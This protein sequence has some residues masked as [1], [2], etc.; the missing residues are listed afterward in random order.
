MTVTPYSLTVV[1]PVFNEAAEIGG[2]LAAL[3]SALSATSFAADVVVVDDGSSDGSAA[4]VQAARLETP[5]QLLAQENQGRF[6]ARRAGIEHAEGDFCLLLDS[7]VRIDPGALAYLEQRLQAGPEEQVW[8]AHVDIE[9][10]GNPYGVFW[11]VLTR[12]AYWTYFREPRTTSFGLDDFDRFPK[13]TTCFLAPRDLLLAAT[14]AFRSSYDDPRFANDDAPLIRWLAGRVPINI[15]P[16]FS[17]RY[18]S[19]R[20]LGPFLRHAFHRGT[21]F[22]DG[23]GHRNAGWFPI[24]VGLFAG[25]AGC[26]A[27]ALRRPLATISA[28]TAATSAAGAAVA[29]S[30][31]RAADAP[32]MAWVT[33]LYAS[34]HIAGMWRGLFMRVRTR[35]EA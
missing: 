19:R 32:T 5:L 11:D 29:L 8:N 35:A 27:L 31:G 16:S 24:V 33:P 9:R 6:E 3:D 1:I 18:P 28:A 12:R 26:L 20:R 34:A 2:T 4:A 23:H 22:V 25:S 10:E 30:E 7:R 21:V 17:C 13:G 15:S 14:A